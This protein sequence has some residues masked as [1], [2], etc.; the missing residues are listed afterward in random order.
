MK[1]SLYKLGMIMWMGVCTAM[2]VHAQTTTTLTLE[3]CRARA[4]DQ[5][6]TLR[7]AKSSVTAAK[8]ASREA[9]TKYF[10]SVS[11][12]GF[13]YNANKGLIEMEMSPEMQMSMLKNGVL[14]GITLT[15]PIFAGG[16]IVNG[17]KLAKVGVEV[18][19]LQQEQTRKEV[20][21]TVEKYYWQV[22]TLE[23]KKKT[24]QSVYEML[25]QICSEVQ[26]SV[27][28]GITT[29]NDLLQVKLRQNDIKSNLL[30]LD[31]NL[32][33]S[34]MV[35][36]QYIGLNGEEIA[37]VPEEQMDA[38]PTFPSE[39]AVDHATA[40]LN[41]PEYKLLDRNVRAN[42]L[43]KRLAVGKNL[44]SVGAGVGY[45]YDNL[46]DK[47]HP[48]GVAYVTVSVPLSGWWGGS[49]AIK[50]QKAKLDIA[51]NTLS[52]SSDLLIIQMRHLWNEV[53]DAYQQL[54]IARDSEEQSTENLRLNRNY[55]QAGMSTM[56]D[57]LD[58]QSL[59]QQSRDQWTD[60]YS[61]FK[62]K[63]LEYCHAT[64]QR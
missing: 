23:E 42:R 9:F 4:L 27:D 62:I 58:A 11:A 52:D 21:L 59:F 45:M 48:F 7:N 19:Q 39:L 14:G 18:S 8:E 16:Q 5:N 20:L 40:L 36:A 44:P 6:M 12:T 22:I 10:P 13:G 15:Q 53:E 51:Q 47:D 37:V 31:N 55:Y 17:N 30:N 34:Y 28:A 61:Q 50:Q 54:L 41:T 32:K 63:V 35:L 29:R 25:T 33:L 2:G 1:L 43:Q 46:M 64:G 26:T 60:S 38:V 24:L 3:D 56:S 49:H 57:L